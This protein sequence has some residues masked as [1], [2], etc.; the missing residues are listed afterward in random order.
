MAFAFDFSGILAAVSA[1]SPVP[2]GERSTT[3]AAA[4][5]AESPNPVPFVTLRHKP[6]LRVATGHAATTREIREI[7]ASSPLQVAFLILVDRALSA[8]HSRGQD[9]CAEHVAGLMSELRSLDP[10]AIIL[11]SASPEIEAGEREA[12]RMVQMRCAACQVSACAHSAR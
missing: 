11:R 9:A 2:R 12:I 4:E 5:Q 3:T 1:A 8:A 7:G 6:L 10:T